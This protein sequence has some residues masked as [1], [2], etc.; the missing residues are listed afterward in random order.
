MTGVALHI[1][2]DYFLYRQAIAMHFQGFWLMN[3]YIVGWSTA[4]LAV[5]IGLLLLK[6]L[7]SLSK[8]L[9]TIEGYVDGIELMVSYALTQKPWMRNTLTENMQEVFGS[10]SWLLPTPPFPSGGLCQSSES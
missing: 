6:Q 5:C 2:T 10:S 7:M 4:V 3:L 9:T 1:G 8:N